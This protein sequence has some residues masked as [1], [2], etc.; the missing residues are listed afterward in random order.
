MVD[1]FAKENEI[2]QSLV[3]AFYSWYQKELYGKNFFGAFKEFYPNCKEA[4]NKLNPVSWN[5]ES[6]KSTSEKIKAV[7]ELK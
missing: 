2:H 6:I 4:V 1:R 5:E 7:F 3:Y